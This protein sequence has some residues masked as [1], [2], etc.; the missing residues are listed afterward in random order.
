M[1]GNLFGLGFG[2][3]IFLAILALIVFGPRRLPEVART[4]SRLIQQLRQVA[5]EAQEEVRQMMG[6]GQP[7]P[8]READRQPSAPRHPPAAAP[9]TP[10][11][12]LPWERGAVPSSSAGRPVEPA[13][14]GGLALS[15]PAAP[16]PE[17]ATEDEP[18]SPSPSLAG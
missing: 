6:E 17:Q 18:E 11:S 12:P 9:N 5:D 1:G 7:Q 4:V 2:E 13:A 3:L 15:E 16:P 14:A 10:M 8:G